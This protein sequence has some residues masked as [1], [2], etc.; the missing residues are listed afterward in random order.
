[1]PDIIAHRSPNL[2][3][4]SCPTLSP[5]GLTAGSTM[6]HEG[7]NG[8][9]SKTTATLGMAPRRGDGR[10]WAISDAFRDFL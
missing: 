3:Q 7:D 2:G 10:T 4:S 5:R 6:Q 8:Y 1:M 9:G